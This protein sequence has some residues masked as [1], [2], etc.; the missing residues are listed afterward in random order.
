M[1]LF[2]SELT[3]CDVLKCLSVSVNRQPP[4]VHLFPSGPGFV[5]ASEGVAAGVSSSCLLVA[6]QGVSAASALF[7]WTQTHLLTHI[8]SRTL[9]SNDVLF[10]PLY[11][12]WSLWTLQTEPPGQTSTVQWGGKTGG[13]HHQQILW[14]VPTFLY[15]AE[16]LCESADNNIHKLAVKRNVCC[17]LMHKLQILF[18]VVNKDISY[19]PL[20]LS[21]EG[22]NVLLWFLSKSNWKT[23]AFM[24]GFK[25]CLVDIIEL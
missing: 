5:A 12:H 16:K 25:I 18:P 6:T 7:R 11:K 23:V 15:S 3:H 2:I 20:L 8:L 1:H 19:F 22:L 17:P 24:T 4:S 10:V 9:S 13:G 21:A 14:A